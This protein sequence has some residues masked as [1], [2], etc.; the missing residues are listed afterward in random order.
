MRSLG[1]AFP[2]QDVWRLIS[3]KKRVWLSLKANR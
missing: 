1:L 3:S 2:A